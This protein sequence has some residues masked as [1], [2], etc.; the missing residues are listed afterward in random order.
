MSKS[1]ETNK[2]NPAWLIGLLC[3]IV[4][5][6]TNC[7]CL[8]FQLIIIHAFVL[9][10]PGETS[11]SQIIFGLQSFFS[12]N[13]ETRSTPPFI[14]PISWI[15]LLKLISICKITFFPLCEHFL[16][17]C[18]MALDGILLLCLWGCKNRLDPVTLSPLTC[19][20]SLPAQLPRDFGCERSWLCC[21]VWSQSSNLWCQH[22]F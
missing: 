8:L 22:T 3:A 16:W 17:G 20:W 13:S 12:G 4:W 14:V 2:K 1:N 21:T 19:S 18:K 5:C 15:N 10:A 7:C 6:S 9:V 11:H